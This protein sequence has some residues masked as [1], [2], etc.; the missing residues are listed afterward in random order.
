MY[1]MTFSANVVLAA[2]NVLADTIHHEMGLV[3]GQ[4]HVVYWSNINST[5]SRGPG[6]EGPWPHELQ[7][8]T[9]TMTTINTTLYIL[10]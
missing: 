2:G 6:M 9:Q 5:V 7:P 4:V 3:Y 10:H 1:T 8:H